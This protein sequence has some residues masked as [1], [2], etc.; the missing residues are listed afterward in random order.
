MNNLRYII[1]LFILLMLSC[2]GI[3]QSLD[4]LNRLLSHTISSSAKATLYNEITWASHI[5]NDDSTLLLGEQAI[6]FSTQYGLEKPLAK[7][8]LQLAEI[9][10]TSNELDL[11][12]NYLNEAHVLISSKK[13]WQEMQV[14]Y[15]LFKG[16]LAFSEY[17][18]DL[19]LS[20]L[21]QG[22]DL[23]Q[24]INA[25]FCYDFCRQLSLVYER[26]GNQDQTINYLKQ[27]IPC[28]KQVEQKITIYNDLGNAYAMQ[29][30]YA[31]A[32][33]LY[34]QN[35]SLSIA[36]NN[37]LEES[38]AYLNIGNLHFLESQWEKAI[39]FY[40]KSAAIKDS[41]D[42][43]KGLAELHQNIAAVYQTQ[44]R[45]NKTLEYY[46]KC[47]Y[48]YASTQDSSSLADLQV[49]IGIISMQQGNL[50][51]AIQ[52]FTDVLTSLKKYLA[53]P[54]LLNAETNLGLAHMSMG[55]HQLALEYFNLAN[56]EA[57]KQ[58]NHSAIANINNLHGANYFYLEDYATSIQY[59][60]KALSLS[61]EFKMVEDQKSALFGLYE[62]NEYLGNTKEALAW[63][64]KYVAIKDSLYNTAT[65]NRI[66]ELQEQYDTKQKEQ[67]IQQLN[68]E[69]KNIALES[70]LKTKRL[71]Q[72]LLIIIFGTVVMCFLGLLWWYRNKE[73]KERL[74][75]T[76]VLHEKQVNQLLNQQEI[77]MLDA[78][79][80]AQQKER[81]GVAKEIHDTL[82]SYLA[83]L[84]Y[85]HEAGKEL[86]SSP[87]IQEQYQLMEQL[88]GQTA[89]EVRS[90]AHQMATGEKFDFDLQA[91]IDQLVNR[92]RNTQQFD[93]QFNYFGEAYAIPRDLELTL[94]RVTQELLSNILKHAQ[95]TE[96]MV[97][98]NQNESEL[99][100]MVEDNGRGF[101]VQQSNS[102]KGLGL[103]SIRER[104][105]PFKGQVN[106]DSHP[107]HGTTVIITIP[108]V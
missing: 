75:H 54:T 9:H 58:N 70:E 90:I 102:K 64:K 15:L 20:T 92:I 65:T 10:R 52:E 39:N 74:Q 21:N 11:A 46:D 69:N 67:A 26:I 94:Y 103:H 63:H 19:A 4:S 60:Q 71:N 61:Q 78:V 47:I 5:Q 8:Y 84:K 99:T 95:A 51:K 93:L 18:N 80:E 29:G 98:I 108:I 81:K 101:E 37:K 36:T 35:T 55:N 72:F 89:K 30:L 6:A 100:L 73:Q 104:M 32:L 33:K 43:K 76:Q 50:S 34:S 25:E 12:T 38:R 1:C 83:T 27:G 44:G 53:P 106:I 42:D 97:Q 31:D 66:A 14:Q 41:I 48:Y 22:Y 85:Q 17:K 68:I 88:I 57:Q 86:A 105:A 59:Y 40:L 62:S 96:A 23:N 77:E 56:Q 107:Q 45:Y 49:N 79:V 87:P 91:A 2:S 13:N 24:K 7:A 3:A 16:K 82:G 28:A